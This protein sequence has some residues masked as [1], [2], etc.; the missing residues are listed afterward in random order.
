[1]PAGRPELRTS[2]A[3]FTRPGPKPNSHSTAEMSAAAKSRHYALELIG[4]SVTIIVL[5]GSPLCI[6]IDAV[7]VLR[8]IVSR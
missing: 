6:M 2:R 4:A 5:V 7:D 1:M 8:L 3:I